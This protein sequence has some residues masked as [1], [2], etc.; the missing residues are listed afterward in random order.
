[1][2]LG[3]AE[4]DGG[5]VGDEVG[6]GAGVAI[7]VKEGLGVGI[8]V[9]GG[10]VGVCVGGF[11]VIVGGIGVGVGGVGVCVGGIGVGVIGIGVGVGVGLIVTTVIWLLVPPMYSFEVVGFTVATV[12]K[13]SK[14]QLNFKLAMIPCVEP[15][16]TSSV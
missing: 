14:Y 1:M 7:G 11:G 3:D 16:S 8:G 5:T 10:G 6:V 13:L 12:L 2:G 15:S 4:V 9:G